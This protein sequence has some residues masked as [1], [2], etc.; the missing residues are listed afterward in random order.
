M[1]AEA[2]KRAENLK[3][4]Q[5][6]FAA[7]ERH[8]KDRQLELQQTRAN[9]EVNELKR[10]MTQLQAATENTIHILSCQRSRPTWLPCN[11]SGRP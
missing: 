9:L 2:E 1:K 4:R 5:D 8:E 11:R 6:R 10:V 3:L 7:A